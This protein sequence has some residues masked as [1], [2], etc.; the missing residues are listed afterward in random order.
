MDKS[1]LKMHLDKLKVNQGYYSLDGDILPD[2]LVLYQNYNMW[3]VFYFDER[4]NRKDER[5]FMTE[6]DA[7]NYILEHFK[8]QKEIERRFK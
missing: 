2:R 4:G 6:S 8:K 5:V 7:C 1:D 3:E